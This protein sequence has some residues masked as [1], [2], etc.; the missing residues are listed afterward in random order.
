MSDTTHAL[1]EA[2]KETRGRIRHLA[3]ELE[4]DSDK[5]GDIVG[6]IGREARNIQKYGKPERVLN[7]LGELQQLGAGFDRKLSVLL[8]EIRKMDMLRDLWSTASTEEN[9]RIKAEAGKR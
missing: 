2:V 3:R 9:N 7:D 8:H 4:L 1:A 6:Y 5:I